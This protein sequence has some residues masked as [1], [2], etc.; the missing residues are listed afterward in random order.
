MDGMIVLNQS[1]RALDADLDTPISLFKRYVDSNQGF[2]LESA[3]VDGRAGRYSVVGFQFLLRLSCAEGRL[4]VAV[5]DSRLEPLKEF[6]GMPFVE[7]LRAVTRALAVC[8]DGSVPSDIPAITRGL[9]GYL[10]YETVTLFEPSLNDVL[11]PSDAEAC[12]VLPGEIVLLDHVYNRSYILSVAQLPPKSS[13][14]HED[15]DRPVPLP[16]VGSV[17]RT[18]SRENYIAGVERLCGEIRR[19]EVIQ[20]V[21]SVRHSAPFEGDEFT[22]YR[23]L[24]HINP[25]P[26]MF[27]M[28]LPSL[29]LLGSSPEMM[30]KCTED[31]LT[32]SPI[33]GTRPRGK[34]D[35]EDDALAAE[36]LGN[37]KERAEHTMLVDLGRNDLGRISQ[38]GT[39]NVDRFMD[40][41]RFSH[42][43]HLTSR[44]TSRIN[45]E[46]DVVGVLAATLP[47]GTLSGAPKIKAIRMLAEIEKIGRGP[48]GGCVGWIGLDKGT[49]NLDMGIIIRSAWIRDRQMN[50]QAGAGIV[51]DSVGANEWAECN[52]KAAAIRAA[53]EN[54]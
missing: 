42:V 9:Y 34:S 54:K 31:R 40:V 10:G 1:C 8:P 36:L 29:T 50:W 19:G 18:L 47:A 32:L 23:R 43:M 15:L 3:E 53:L 14:L 35:E 11:P 20:A 52:N 17:S 48:Y 37:E 51:H 24:R 30:V 7:G 45:K 6:D 5:R 16:R 39:V 38:A 33:A 49:R 28:R 41:Q 44:I 13:R 12:L 2:L 22:L 27:F 46:T 4:V 26:Y 21:L 25:S